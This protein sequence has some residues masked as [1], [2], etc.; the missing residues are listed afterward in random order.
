MAFVTDF[1]CMKCHQPRHENKDMY[2]SRLGTCQSCWDKQE[3]ASKDLYLEL[4]KSKN[5]TLEERVAKL[6]SD[7]YDLKYRKC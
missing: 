5:V 6:E 1:I 3:K 2:V 7:L 4:L